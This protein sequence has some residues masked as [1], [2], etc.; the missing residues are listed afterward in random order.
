MDFL[1][2]I[3]IKAQRVNEPHQYA[4]QS[5]VCRY[6]ESGESTDVRLDAGSQA[7]KQAAAKV[8]RRMAADLDAGK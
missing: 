6:V 5:I 3:E 1:F 2:D 7:M 4:Q 8:L